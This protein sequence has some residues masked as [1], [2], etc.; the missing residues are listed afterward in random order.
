[1]ACREY[2]DLHEPVFWKA[3]LYNLWLD[4]L[5]TLHADM[6]GEKHFP[7]AMRTKA[8]QMKQL[9]AQS[10]RGPNLRHDT[11]LYAKQSYTA[12]PECEYPASY[13]EPYPEFYARVKYFAE[14]AGRLFE[15]ADYTAKNAQRAAQLKVIKQRQMAFFKKMAETVGTL[16]TLA[17]KELKAEP[18]TEQEKAFVKKTVDI[19]GGGSGPPRYDGWYCDLFYTRLECAKWDPIVAD[20]H[21][22]PSD[23]SLQGGACLEVAVGD[24]N[25]GMIAV[26]NEND[27]AVYAGPL[28]SY[29]EF[30][31]PVKDRLTDQQWQEMIR[32]GKAPARPSWVEAFQA[33]AVERVPQRGK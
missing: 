4:S 30:L 19:R 9:Q 27:R 24:V 18:F 10:A 13:V 7:E 16:E 6:S 25:L 21:T 20:V 26:D 32:T 12:Y 15:A 17:K 31:Q 14:E 3:N 2:V 28:Y 29:Y 33:P 22:D 8:W 23:W 1:M 11:I 5:R